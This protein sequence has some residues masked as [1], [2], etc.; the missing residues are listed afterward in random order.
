M[1]EFGL[2]LGTNERPNV[3]F[4]V[5]S[6]YVSDLNIQRGKASD[7]KGDI[8]RILVYFASTRQ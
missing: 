3:L 2:C 7:C 6:K 1:L 4:H 8:R 5:G